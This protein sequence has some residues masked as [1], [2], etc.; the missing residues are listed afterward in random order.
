MDRLNPR[1]AITA[2]AP[3]VLLTCCAPALALL[4]PTVVDGADL[5]KQETIDKADEV[6][7]QVKR[8]F[9]KDLMIETYKTIPVDQQAD[10]QRKGKEQFY[11]QWIE[12]RAQALGV[13]GIMILIT[14]EPGRIQVVADRATQQKAFSAQDRE[15]L[16]GI[17]ANAFRQQQFDEGLTAAVE[18]VRTRLERNAGGAAAGAGDPRDPAGAPA[19]GPSTQPAIADKPGTVATA[20]TTAPATAPTTRPVNEF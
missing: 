14:K 3:L 20:P 1:T 9:G 2:L 19:T 5:F 18:F 11:D 12:S 8:Q 17:L 7:R 16:K 15:E 4:R 10:F 13:N 6:I